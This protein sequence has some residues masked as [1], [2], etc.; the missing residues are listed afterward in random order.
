MIY[1]PGAR[2]AQL[3]TLGSGNSASLTLN[4]SSNVWRGQDV[5]LLIP[6]GILNRH[7]ESDPQE[8]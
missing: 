3:L 6:R 4:Q 2:R 7:A 8:L 1:C 5:A